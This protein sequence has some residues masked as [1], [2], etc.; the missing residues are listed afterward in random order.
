QLLED[1]SDGCVVVQD[2]KY[3]YTNKR[4]GEIFGYESK[5]V[6]GMSVG[7]LSWTEDREAAREWYEKYARG[8]AAS[9]ERYEGAVIKEDGTQVVVEATLRAIEYE[10]K[11]AILAISRDVTESRRAEAIIRESEEKLRLIFESVTEGIIFTD[12]KGKILD[13]N[14]G[15]VRMYGYDTKEELIG[16]E[17]IEVVAARD[18]ARIVKGRNN[19]LETGGIGMMPCA[20]VRKDGSEFP[21]MMSG[22]ML[23][24]AAGE[25]IGFVTVT[26]DISE[27]QKMQERLMLAERLASIGQL[28]AGVAHEINNPLGG[29]MG[30]SRLLLESD[31]PDGIREDVEIINKEAERAANVVK[32]LLTFARDTG[33]AKDLMDINDI[34]QEVLQLRSHNLIENNIEVEARFAPDLPLIIVSRAQMQQVFMN[35]IVNAE[36]AMVAAHGRGRLKVTTEEAPDMVRV[37]VDDDGPGISPENMKKIF[38]PFFTTRDVGKGTG[39]G[40]S[41]SHGIATEHGG[42]LYAESEPGQGASFIL[43][44]PIPASQD[45]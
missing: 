16:R 35:L 39:L 6:I 36:Q 41:I 28:A 45:E 1:M 5:Q 42:V 37:S 40:L 8:E 44:L 33:T 13:V 10:G 3:V 38:T 32:G 31:I 11:P 30:V 26:V 29:V 2:G 9:V 20:F 7:D 25:P 24:D 15:A 34:V 12:L 14:K 17:G 4:F 43:E 19:S 18:H 27:Q 22:A 21:A 23:R